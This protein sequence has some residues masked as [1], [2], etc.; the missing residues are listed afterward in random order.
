MALGKTA[1][2]FNKLGVSSDAEAEYPS[3]PGVSIS[4]AGCS[5]FFGFKYHVGPA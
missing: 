3:A 5:D 1:P 2:I 4:P